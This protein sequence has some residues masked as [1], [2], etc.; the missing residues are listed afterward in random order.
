MGKDILSLFVTSEITGTLIK[1]LYKWTILLLAVAGIYWI[2]ELLEWY[3]FLERA[4]DS[5]RNSLRYFYSYKLQPI[6]GLIIMFLSIIGQILNYKG[7]GFIL[8]AIKSSD[9]V[10]LNKGFK[11][12]YTTYF[13]VFISFAVS[14]ISIGYR[15]LR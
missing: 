14:I 6:I 2:L 1:K 15:L 13:L 7:Y 10:L 11:N 4:P 3:R 9:A 5:I 8:S 12:F